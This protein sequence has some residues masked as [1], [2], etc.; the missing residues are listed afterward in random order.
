MC[1]RC[2]DVKICR[3]V[4]DEA[5]CFCP[6]EAVSKLALNVSLRFTASKRVKTDNN[7]LHRIMPYITH[8]SSPE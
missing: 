8:T 3:F 2:K 6:G 4:Y 5:L 1:K 7:G